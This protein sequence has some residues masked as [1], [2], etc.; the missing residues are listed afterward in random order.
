[1][2]GKI[3]NPQALPALEE[4]LRRDNIRYYDYVAIRNALEALG[5]QVDIERDF[6]GDRITIHWPKWRA[7]IGDYV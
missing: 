1:M 2:P 6:S 7:D 4:A 3:G 5:G